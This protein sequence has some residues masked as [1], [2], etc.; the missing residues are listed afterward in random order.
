MYNISPYL[1]TIKTVYYSDNKI[2]VNYYI[3]V[4]GYGLRVNKT[5][6]EK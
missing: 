6:G 3:L 2:M 5:T 1:E 4:L